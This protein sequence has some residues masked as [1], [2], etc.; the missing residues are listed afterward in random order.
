MAPIVA[1]LRAGIAAGTVEG[2][3][4]TLLLSFTHMFVNR[5]EAVDPNRAES[6]YYDFIRRF[7]VAAL[8]RGSERPLP[9]RG[10]D[11]VATAL[12]H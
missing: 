1:A 8:A 10:H 11:D 6:R 9:Q 2:P 5:V 12:V 7:H 3:A 4:E